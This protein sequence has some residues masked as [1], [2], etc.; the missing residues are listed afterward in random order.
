MSDEA[1]EE[2]NNNNNKLEVFGRILD[3]YCIPV[4]FKEREIDDDHAASFIM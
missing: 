3:C 4:Q 1:W 2:S